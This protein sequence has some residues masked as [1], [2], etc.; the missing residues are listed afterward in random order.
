[1]RDSRP[2]Y[3]QAERVNRYRMGAER[4]SASWHPKCAEPREHEEERSFRL[5]SNGAAVIPIIGPTEKYASIFLDFFGGMSSDQLRNQ[6]LDA[7]QDDDVD[8]IFLLIDSPGGEVAGTAELADALASVRGIKPTWAHA[9]DLA[10]SAAYWVG[11]QAETFTAN[12]T[13]EIGSIGTI[14]IMPDT[15]EAW[16]KEGVEWHVIQ[17]GPYKAM[18][19][20]LTGVDEDQLDYLNELLMK[21]AQPF[22]DAVEAGRPAIT[23]SQMRELRKAG[24][25][26]AQQDGIEMGLVDD[27]MG[28]DAAFAAFGDR[29]RET[30]PALRAA[31]R[32]RSARR[33]AAIAGAMSVLGEEKLVRDN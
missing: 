23:D 2:F 1:M 5:Y 25:Y 22:Y 7:A 32:K 31:R 18:T 33:R 28:K 17:T 6:I 9:D 3:I 15:K 11:S 21:L 4:K 26:V 20:G 13:A 10:A 27:V 12:R 30:A 24:I 16:A 8:G 29:I 19:S 14:A